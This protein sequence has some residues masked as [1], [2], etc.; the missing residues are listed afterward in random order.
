[1]MKLC[2]Y[3]MPGL[4]A[5]LSCMAFAGC[6]DDEKLSVLPT[7]SGFQITPSSPEKGQTVRVEAVQSQIGS[8]LY[9]ADY[10]WVLTYGEDEVVRQEDR[11]VYDN[12]PANPVFVYTFPDDAYEGTYTLRFTGTYQYSATA[13]SLVSGGNYETPGDY[14]AGK[15]TVTQSAALEGTCAGRC[16]FRVRAK[17]N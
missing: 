1:M 10:T 16:S 17:S 8:L 3:M 13:A 9:R 2:R 5:V 6:E 12:N 14:T 4:A 15:I 11:V 7:F